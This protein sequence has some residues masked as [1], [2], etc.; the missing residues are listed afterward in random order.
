MTEKFVRQVWDLHVSQFRRVVLWYKREDE[1][2]LLTIKMFNTGKCEEKINLTIA[3]TLQIPMDSIFNSTVRETTVISN[4]RR[5]LEVRVFQNDDEVSL[6][7]FKINPSNSWTKQTLTLYKEEV[8]VLNKYLQE[9]ISQDVDKPLP[10]VLLS[11]KSV[12]DLLD[13]TVLD[14]MDIS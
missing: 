3:E 8:V 11:Y 9:I 7:L 12:P 13:E 10:T 5:K 2:E 1:I 6:T 14:P 4:G